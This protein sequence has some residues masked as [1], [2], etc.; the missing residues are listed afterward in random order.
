MK[1]IK[2][3]IVYKFNKFG[4]TYNRFMD[5]AQVTFDFII[6]HKKDELLNVLYRDEVGCIDLVWNDRFKKAGI[7]HIIDKHVGKGKD[8]RNTVVMMRIIYD[9]IQ[10]GIIIKEKWDKVTFEKDGKRVIVSKNVRDKNGD[11]IEK[12]NWVVTAFDNNIPKK[13]KKRRNNN[14]LTP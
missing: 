10:N 13:K 8:F 12:K 7:K 9:V 11:I 1:I 14:P 3:H 5:V 6:C 4:Y 2:Q